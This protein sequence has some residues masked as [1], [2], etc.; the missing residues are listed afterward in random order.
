MINDTDAKASQVQEQYYQGFLSDEER[1]KLVVKTWS[2]LDENIKGFLA[3]RVKD[4]DN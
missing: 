4:A 1:Y 3:S 2:D